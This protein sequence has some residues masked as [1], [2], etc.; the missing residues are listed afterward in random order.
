M[1]SIFALLQYGNPYFSKES[2]KRKCIFLEECCYLY[3]YTV[4]SNLF[5]LPVHFLECI[6]FNNN[7][8]NDPALFWSDWLFL[9]CLSLFFVLDPIPPI[10][11]YSALFQPKSFQLNSKPNHLGKVL[12]A[13]YIAHCI[14]RRKCILMHPS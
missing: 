9:Y 12:C 6:H 14:E 10:P 2:R 13:F 11:I 3:K 1:E 7:H 5:Y 8:A 4:F